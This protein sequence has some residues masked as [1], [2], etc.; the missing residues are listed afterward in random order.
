MY[1]RRI[2]LDPKERIKKEGG[3]IRNHDT[4][5]LK[6]SDKEEKLNP[7]QGGIKIYRN[8]QAEG[9]PLRRKDARYTFYDLMTSDNPEDEQIRQN[10]FEDWVFPEVRKAT[11]DN[12]TTSDIIIPVR[13]TYHGISR[14]P[15]TKNDEGYTQMMPDTVTQYAYI[16]LNPSLAPIRTF[17][18][19]PG[20][21][22]SRMHYMV[23]VEVGDPRTG[24]LDNSFI[25]YALP[26][27][28]PISAC[29]KV[30]TVDRNPE[31]GEFDTFYEV[32]GDPELEKK[33]FDAWFNG[34]DYYFNSCIYPKIRSYM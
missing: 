25:R 29:C 7:N 2:P 23:C 27:N 11:L 26:L 6:G 22:G 10:C 12:G 34:K 9:G 16:M 5:K 20:M 1:N 4:I 31:N 3:V 13:S 21:T 28:T 18:A 32:K 30:V 8:L 19:F 17:G 15:A 33:I 14:I 24:R